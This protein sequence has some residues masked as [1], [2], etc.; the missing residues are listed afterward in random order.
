MRRCQE[1]ERML[2]Q[3][4]PAR[5]RK[6][7]IL[8][9]LGPASATP[10]MIGKLFRAGADAFRINM[11]HTPHDKMRELVATIRNVESSYGRPI[12]ILVDLQ[13]PKLRLGAFALGFLARF[14]RLAAHM[15]DT[16][17]KNAMRLHR[18]VIRRADQTHQHIA[19]IVDVAILR[20]LQ[21]RP[22]AEIAPVPATL[23]PRSRSSWV[24]FSIIPIANIKPALGPPTPEILKSTSIGNLAVVPT[25]IPIAGLPSPS[26]AGSS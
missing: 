23:L 6:V 14:H 1:V 11:S 16:D 22:E 8:A 7:R 12:G 18:V 20:H 17:G 4:L 26:D 15:T 5:G 10:E 3:Y 19:V 9:T 24:N 25:K 2:T 21:R 13:G